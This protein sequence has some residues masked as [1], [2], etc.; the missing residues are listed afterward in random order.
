MQSHGSK[1][2]GRDAL[3]T[4][5]LRAWNDGA[6]HK[7]KH[8]SGSPVVVGSCRFVHAR[9]NFPHRPLTIIIS[10]RTCH[11]KG[12]MCHCIAKHKQAMIMCTS[13]SSTYPRMG[14]RYRAHSVP[15]V[16]QR[17]LIQSDIGMNIDPDSNNVAPT[18]TCHGHRCQSG[19][20]SAR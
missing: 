4:T 13:P 5:E 17:F 3:S 10:R 19:R 8:A 9:L 14:A 6:L 2:T 12:L 11:I 18:P 1:S 20:C 7:L 15:F 16:Q